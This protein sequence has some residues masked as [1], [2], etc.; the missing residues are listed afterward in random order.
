MNYRR[1]SAIIGHALLL[2]LFASVTVRA[3]AQVGTLTSL[4]SF[5]GSAGPSAPLIQGTDHALYGTTFQGG[6]NGKGSIFKIPPGGTV[7]P[8]HDFAASGNEG[9]FPY[10]GLVQAP[11]GNFYG[12]ATGGTPYGVIYEITPTGTFS[13]VHTF[14][15]IDGAIPYSTL[16]VGSDGFLYGTAGVGGGSGSSGAVFKISVAT[17][18]TFQLVHSFSAADKAGTPYGGVIQAP[19]GNF[20]GTTT[21]NAGSAGFGA[22]YRVTPGGVF[23]LLHTFK[24]T[25]NNVV[26]GAFPYASL[27]AAPD[28]YLYGVTSN[29]GTTANGT[30][31]KIGLDGTFAIVH[32]FLGGTDGQSPYGA[33][34]KATDGNLYGVTSGAGAGSTTVGTI[35]RVTTSGVFSTIYSFPISGASGA[36]PQA[37]LLQAA[38]GN[39]Y[40]TTQNGGTTGSGTVFLYTTGLAVPRQHNYDLSG[41]G[42]DDLLWQYASNGKIAYIFMNGVIPGAFGYV[43]PNNNIDPNYHVV[44]E[45]DLNGD[46]HPD[47]VFQ[48]LTTGDVSY[49]L[50][51]G[52]TPIGNGFLFKNL[53]KNWKIVGAPDLNG[54]G[55]PDLVFQYQTTGDV[56]YVLMKSDGVTPDPS[57]FHYLIQNIDPNW[58]V[59]AAPDFHANEQPVLLFQHQVLGDVAYIDTVRTTGP[60]GAVISLDKTT[61]AYV[62]QNVDPTWH[63]TGTPDYNGDGF[64]DLLWQNTAS[65]D[66]AAIMMFGTRHIGYYTLFQNVDRNWRVVGD[67]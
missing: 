32:S 13:V 3:R 21:Q 22:V 45:P 31:Y 10:G 16:M 14:N 18:H 5:T 12:T 8:M 59:V 7:T 66:V 15:L 19:D 33:L 62:F 54:D 9:A 35:F 30:I 60:N 64:P 57:S 39:F 26:D 6:A 24:S 37:A 17:P 34:I 49:V 53:D 56:A 43:F 51:N 46:G 55:H 20:Y 65:G 28:G 47:M 40:G 44:A 63:I 67:K 42:M 58:H 50:L 27:V 29:G 23:T 1:L 52:L 25:V 36:G 61:F 38:D 48:N 11:D 4:T 2:A 41:D